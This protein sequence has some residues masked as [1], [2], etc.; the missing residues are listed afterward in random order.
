MFNKKAEKPK[1][2]SGTLTIFKGPKGKTNG[3][4]FFFLGGI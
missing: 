1:N 3:D 4:F 2:N